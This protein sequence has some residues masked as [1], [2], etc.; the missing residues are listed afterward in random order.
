MPT[1]YFGQ[2]DGRFAKLLFG[3]WTH[4]GFNRAWNTPS[5]QSPP[6][7][8]LKLKHLKQ[9]RRA[10]MEVAIGLIREEAMAEDAVTFPGDEFHHKLITPIAVVS[11]H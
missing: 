11:S 10:N 5:S 8:S 2:S 1:N 9:A 6:S 7:W 4:C 3:P